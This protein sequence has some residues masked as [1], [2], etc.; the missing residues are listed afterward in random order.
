MENTG[1]ELACLDERDSQCIGTVHMRESLSGTGTP[2]PRCDGHWEKRLKWQEE[3][4]RKYP[5][6]DMPPAWF[7]PTYAGESWDDY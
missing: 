5:D 2:I 3:H 4:D 1:D 7:D 6:S